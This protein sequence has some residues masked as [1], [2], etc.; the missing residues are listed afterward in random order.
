[1]SKVT[2]H[3]FIKTLIERDGRR[4][5]ICCLPIYFNAPYQRTRGGSRQTH[6]CAPTVDHIVPVSRGGRR[7]ELSNLRL[8]HRL[9]NQSRSARDTP[10]PLHLSKVARLVA[11]LGLHKER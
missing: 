9:C 4:C 5:Q 1:M 11:E 2:L 3:A 7:G 6:P 8:A 10:N